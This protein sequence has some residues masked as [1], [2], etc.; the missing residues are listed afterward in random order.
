M[1]CNIN[2]GL[3]I[4]SIIL[5]ISITILVLYKNMEDN[6]QENIKENF[7]IQQSLQLQKSLGNIVVDN[8]IK[9]NNTTL[10]LNPIGYPGELLE[11]KFNE[12]FNL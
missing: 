8:N 5:I 1:K 11:P 3:G 10:L 7:S 6:V 9:L 2:I 12:Y 4:I